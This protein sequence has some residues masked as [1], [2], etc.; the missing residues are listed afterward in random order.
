[1]DNAGISYVIVSIGAPGIQGIPDTA[2]ATLFSKEINDDIYE[3]YVK[4]YPTRFG[5]FATV[6]MQTVTAAALELDRAVTSLGAKGAMIHGY[7]EVINPATGAVEIQYLDDPRCLPF[8]A[9]VAELGVPIYLHPRAPPV[10]QQLMF[11][12]ADNSRSKYPGLVTAGWGFTAEAAVHSLRLMLSGLFDVYP[13]LQIILGHAG[14]GLPFLIHRI[15]TQ[16]SAD[17]AHHL[18]A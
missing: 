4:P 15:D 5:F 2:N 16:I 17:A 10:S 6:P 14:E 3:T 1:M 9:K 7:T 11:N 13:D 18:S 8:W 12:H